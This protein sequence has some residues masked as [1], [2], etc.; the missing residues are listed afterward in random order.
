MAGG[1]GRPRHQ[2]RGEKSAVIRRVSVI[3]PPP[4][5]P[6]VEIASNNSFPYPEGRS[7][8]STKQYC[9]QVSTWSFGRMVWFTL[10]WTN[11]STTVS[12][13]VGYCLVG[14]HV[15]LELNRNMSVTIPAGGSALIA[16]PGT[17]PANVRPATTVIGQGCTATRRDLVMTITPDGG[18]AL[19]AGRVGGVIPAGV[20]TGIE[21]SVSYV[22]E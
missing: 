17:L 20:L 7:D 22:V 16:A 13:G 2:I 10:V 15:S 8:V 19:Y 5:K 14:R 21:M 3:V 12:N 1:G 11:I 6:Y 18:I 9:D 4:G